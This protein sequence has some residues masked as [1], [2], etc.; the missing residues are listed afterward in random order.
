MYGMI[1]IHKIRVGP[2]P[3]SVAKK[4]GEEDIVIAFLINKMI[5]LLSRFR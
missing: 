5:S 2:R 1:L 3:L 4:E